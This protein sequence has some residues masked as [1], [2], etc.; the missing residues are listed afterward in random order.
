MVPS[1]SLTLDPKTDM[2]CS[3]EACRDELCMTSGRPTRARVNLRC[4]DESVE[5]FYTRRYFT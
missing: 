2:E 1:C 4:L 3:T 5:N